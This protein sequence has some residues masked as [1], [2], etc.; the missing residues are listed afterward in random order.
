M[1]R[2]AARVAPGDALAPGTDPDPTAVRH[3]APPAQLLPDPGRLPAGLR[4]TP[5]DAPRGIPPQTRLQADP[6]AAAGPGHGRQRSQRP[7]RRPA[8][9]RD[10]AALRLPAR[11]RW[12]PRLVGRA[13]GPD[14]RLQDQAHGGPRRGP[15]DRILRFRR[16]H[17]GQAVRRGGRHR[18]GLGHLG[19]R[20]PHARW[21]QERRGRRAQIQTQRREAEGP[22]HDRPNERSWRESAVR[23]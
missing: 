2:F 9:S 4:H 6:G 1:P 11:D 14:A 17:P 19:A 23:E 7:V 21:P 12:R 13:E 5:H 8:P 16:D 20:G 10:A 22:L 18:L 3:N 15:P